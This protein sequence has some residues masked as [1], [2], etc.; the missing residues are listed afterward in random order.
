VLV[1]LFFSG[2]ASGYGVSL[3]VSGLVT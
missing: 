3:L 2:A 1:S